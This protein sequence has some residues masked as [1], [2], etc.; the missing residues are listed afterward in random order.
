[1][2]KEVLER[3]TFREYLDL[4]SA[5]LSLWPQD[6]VK[7]ALALVEKDEVAK[8]LFDEA[9]ALDVFMRVQDAPVNLAALEDKIM[10]RIAKTAQEKTAPALSVAAPAIRPALLFAPGGGLLAAVILGFFWGAGD[11]QTQ[12]DYLLDPV[13]YSQE[14]IIGDDADLTE[15]EVF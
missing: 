4:Y 12:A 7:P 5:D 6:S 8:A 9:L 2:K 10:A 1:M 13:Y 15:E 14:Q 11:I 3:E